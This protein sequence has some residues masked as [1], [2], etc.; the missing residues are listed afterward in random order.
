M[1]QPIFK[2]GKKVYYVEDG[3]IIDFVPKRIEIENG[4]YVYSNA[5]FKQKES[6]LFL[7]KKTAIESEV[8]RL[9]DKILELRE[10]K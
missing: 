3:R 4:A 1:K 8:N 10:G 6:D 7:E 5:P 9:K 2:F